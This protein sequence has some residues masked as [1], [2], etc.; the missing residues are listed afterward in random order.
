MQA[1]SRS[2]ALDIRIEVCISKAHDVPELKHTYTD[3]K[4]MKY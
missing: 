3:I 4:F 2:K 1:K